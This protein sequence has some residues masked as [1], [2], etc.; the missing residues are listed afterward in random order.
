MTDTQKRN[1]NTTGVFSTNIKVFD[2]INNI[3][4]C[5]AFDMTAKKE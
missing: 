3:K 2:Q 1:E 5:R 4:Q